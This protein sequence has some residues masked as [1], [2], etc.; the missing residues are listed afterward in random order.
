MSDDK[1]LLAKG[2]DS[3]GSVIEI[4]AKP[5]YREGS[6]G[7]ADSVQSVEG[8]G[9]VRVPTYMVIAGRAVADSSEPVWSQW[10]DT[11][12]ERL[13]LKDNKNVLGNGKG[14]VYVV[15]I[16]NGGVF[17]GDHEKIRNAVNKNRL[18]NRAMPINPKTEVYP[19]LEAIKAGDT[20]VLKEK[21]WTKSDSLYVFNNF[22]DFDDASRQEGFLADNPGYV[23]LRD[24]DVAKT[25]YRGRQ[26]TSQQRDNHSLIIASG[27]RVPLGK[28]LDQ[29]E[30]FGWESFGSWHDNYDTANSGRVVV[31][32]SYDLGVGSLNSVNNNGRSLG[33]AP[34]E[35]AKREKIVGPVPL[36]KVVEAAAVEREMIP[37]DN[38]RRYLDEVIGLKDSTVKEHLRAIRSYK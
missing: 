8:S 19:L 23:V 25:E 35:L 10:C 2:V 4:N 26:S 31:L 9:L 24:A 27:G 29:A 12:A 5:F 7:V 18:K 14:K 13:T 20:T 16:Q 1:F 36:E 22:G 28:M 3:E 30:S 15:D 17:L 38:I 6:L 34:E 37:E 33:V 32:Y 11:Y 21:G